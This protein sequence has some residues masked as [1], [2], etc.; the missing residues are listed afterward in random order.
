MRQSYSQAEK[1]GSAE[2]SSSLGKIQDQKLVTW[3]TLHGLKFSFQLRTQRLLTDY[4]VAGRILNYMKASYNTS[5]LFQ[6]SR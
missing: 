5:L 6:S 1:Y 4:F 3:H 2:Q